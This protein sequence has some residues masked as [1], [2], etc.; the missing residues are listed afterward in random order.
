MDSLYALLE[1]TLVLVAHPD[2]EAVGCGILLQR[3][4]DPIVVFATDGAPRPDYFWQS[5]GSRERYAEVRTNEAEQALSA[6]GMHHFHFLAE[7]DRIADQELYLNLESAYSALA[8]L[9]ELEIPDAI[10]T[11]AYE[12][13]H[14][15]HDACAF[16]GSVVG[17]RYELPVW[18]VPLYHRSGGETCRQTFLNRTGLPIFASPEE[19]ARKR[20]MFTAY[21]SQAH[22]TAEFTPEFESVRPMIA[23]DFARVPHA[24]VLN[25]EAW[26]WPMKGADLCQAFDTFFTQS[27][28][29][30]RKRKWGTAA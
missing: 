6:I 8:D 18:E 21:K 29:P 24:G 20:T 19:L 15:D 26:R 9:V 25:Y 22:V 16:L 7:P 5:Y 23:Y 30:T 3:M 2:D 4:H 27:A 1:R 11:L 17:E 10:L 13:G 28:D 12:G 14:P